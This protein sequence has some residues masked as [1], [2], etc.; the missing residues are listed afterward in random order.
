MFL[1][2]YVKREVEMKW[3]Y[4]SQLHND[5][6]ES[7][8]RRELRLTVNE[9][10]WNQVTEACLLDTDKNIF[11]NQMIEFCVSSTDMNKICIHRI[12]MN[13]NVFG[14]FYWLR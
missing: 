4:D 9:C 2:L 11:Q 1:C 8:L 12:D 13:L 10:M 14:K 3:L 6:L 5:G 7:W